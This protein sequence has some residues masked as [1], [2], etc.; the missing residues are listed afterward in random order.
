VAGDGL[1]RNQ[2]GPCSADDNSTVESRR[3]YGM[4]R[5]RAPL[6]GRAAA[7]TL[8]AGFLSACGGSESAEPE[9]DVD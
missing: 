6:V 9:T 7:I 4:S 5:S 1:R 8:A 2:S 3:Q